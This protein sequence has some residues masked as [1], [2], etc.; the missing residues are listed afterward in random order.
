MTLTIIVQSILFR[1]CF[2][3]RGHPKGKMGN[4]PSLSNEILIG[5]CD[6]ISFNITSICWLPQPKNVNRKSAGGNLLPNQDSRICSVHFVDGEPTPL[7]P[8]PSL[9]LY[10]EQ[11]S[12]T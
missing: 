11:H 8:Y 6:E 10:S 1:K 2:P 12:K 4:D 9:N 7:H 3:W 5:V